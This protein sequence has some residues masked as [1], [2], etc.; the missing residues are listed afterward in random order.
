MRRGHFLGSAAAAGLA[1]WAGPV[2]A[3]P[4]ASPVNGM[5]FS[6]A[7]N[8]IGA[9]WSIDGGTLRMVSMRDLIGRVAIA[10]P[11]ELFSLT[12]AD[13]RV[14]AASAFAVASSPRV[15]RKVGSP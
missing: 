5:S 2:L 7:S 1:S 11:K 10:V 9:T 6:L 4:P 8:G 13:D 14:V 3:S 15:V 12:L